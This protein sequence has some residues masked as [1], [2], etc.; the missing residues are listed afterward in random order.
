MM[1]KMKNRY[2]TPVIGVI[3]VIAMFVVMMLS[4]ITPNVVFAST[5]DETDD[6]SPY[7]FMLRSATEYSVVAT[8][9]SIQYAMIPDEYNGLPVTEIAPNAFAFFSELEEVFIPESIDTIGYNAFMGCDKLKVVNLTDVE[10]VEEYAFAF[11]EGLETVVLPETVTTVEGYAFM[12]SSPMIYTAQA[13]AQTANWDSWLEFCDGEV[14]YEHTGMVCSTVW[15]NGIS[16]GTAIGYQL[17]SFGTTGNPVNDPTTE[18][19]LDYY[20]GDEG[21]LPILSIE[22]NAFR[23]CTLHSLAVGTNSVHTINVKTAG[24]A[25]SKIQA[26]WFSDDVTFIQS[27]GIASNSVFLMSTLQQVYLPNTLTSIPAGMFQNCAYLTS[28]R[29]TG[30]VYNNRLPSTVTAIGDSVFVGC[31]QLP[32]LYIPSSVTTMG[33]NVFS[34][35]SAAKN[36]YI[37]IYDDEIPATWNMLWSNTNNAVVTYKQPIL[38]DK[39]D[40][41]G[42]TDS[43]KPVYGSAMPAAT[44]PLRTGYTFKG[45]F[46]E[47]DGVGD[48]YYTSEMASAN[49][50]DTEDAITLYAYWEANQ[51]TVILNTQGGESVTNYVEATYGSPMPAAF[52]P[53]RTGYMFGGYYTGTNGT[54]TQYYTASMENANNWNIVG[55]TILY[56]KWTTRDYVAMLNKQGGTGG[57]SSVLVIYDIAMPTATA[58][59]RTG[60]TF[61]GYYTG[62]NGTGTQYY[63]ASMNSARSWN[64]PESTTLYAKWT[65]NTYNVVYNNN[66]PGGASESITGSTSNSS[67]TYGVAQALTA[68]GY[69]LTGY[70]FIGWNTNA[71]GSGTYYSKSEY[72]YYY[73]INGIGLTYTNNLTFVNEN[74]VINLASNQGATVTLYAQWAQIAYSYT[75]M[76]AASDVVNAPTLTYVLY[77]QAITF[78]SN[79]SRFQYWSY[80]SNGIYY[81]T[82]TNPI[83][84]SRLVTTEMANI[85]ITAVYSEKTSSCVATGTLI[86]LADGSQVAVEELTG[87]EMLLVW[88]FF[89]GTFD[90]A[91][92]VFIHAT[93]IDTYEIIHLYFSDGTDVKVIWEHGFW[94]F[95]LNRY[96]Y[97]DEDAAQ[98]IG[99]WFSKQTTDLNG[100]LTWTQV[101]LVNVVIETEYTTAWSPVTYGHLS[102]YV[103]GILSVP[104]QTEILTNIFDVDGDIMQY[105]QDAFAAD[106]LEYGLFTYAE[107]VDIIPVSEEI[108]AAFNGQYLKVAIGKG[109]ITWAEISALIEQYSDLFSE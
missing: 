92:I 51:Y 99:H 72:A 7:M 47:A 109:L 8:D 2:K 40:G 69:S 32:S 46:T 66:K 22:A 62:T 33:R 43:I 34:G 21:Y 67:H 14:V 101:Q 16:N 74:N 86:T 100:D 31:T 58:P 84:L 105:D 61:G 71:N 57:T 75:E 36:I 38:L 95:D 4:S 13:E 107:F 64:I 81:Q 91:P 104:A 82:T 29:F 88:N 98:Y 87:N 73:T 77:E 96:V 45:Y 97:I 59:T 78:S 93:E 89:T 76:V 94:D 85:T 18:F 50:W 55:T 56:A 10:I 35:W 63:T 17:T 80:T 102:F 79:N 49:N 3:A 42:G 68:N 25:N 6:T 23:F 26:F 1:Q 27:P 108:F 106:I 60:Y 90:A 52:M 30:S 12:F 5:F 20:N 41:T 70:R 15:E 28:V 83:T 39:Q 54:G 48:E 53:I 19:Q 37:D 44:A 24:F 9:F 103:N 65:V 11:C